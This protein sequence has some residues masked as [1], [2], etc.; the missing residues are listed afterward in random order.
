MLMH[1]IPS[2]LVVKKNAGTAKCTF[3]GTHS[4][5]VTIVMNF[6]KFVTSKVW[7]WYEEI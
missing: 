7:T 3:G 6:Y 2:Y 1:P 5:T 4:I